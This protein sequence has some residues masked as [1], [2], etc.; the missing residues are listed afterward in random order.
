MA[1]IPFPSLRRVRQWSDEHCGPAVLQMLLG[2]LGKKVSQP[3]LTV[4]AGLTQRKITK[5]GITITQM[6][7]AVAKLVPQ[8]QFWYKNKSSLSDIK[9]IIEKYHFPVGVEWQG[10]FYQYSDNDDGHYCVVTKVDSA[11]K[12][13]VLSDP[14]IAFAKKDR[15]IKMADFKKRWWDINL[16]KNPKTGKVRKV[17]DSNMIFVITPKEISFPEFLGM[18]RG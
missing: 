16:V 4:A 1:K 14:F 15:H 13:I 6:A 17:R 3:K 12:E 8:V 7:Q 2:Y 5:Q 11:K 9:K 10:I 18:K